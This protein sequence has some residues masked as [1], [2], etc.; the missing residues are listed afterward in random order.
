M[1]TALRIQKARE[2][3]I[4]NLRPHLA[5]GYFSKIL[6]D[7]GGKLTGHVGSDTTNQGMFWPIKLPNLRHDQLLTDAQLPKAVVG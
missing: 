5:L 2:K 4:A 6:H 1:V 7:I 3:Q